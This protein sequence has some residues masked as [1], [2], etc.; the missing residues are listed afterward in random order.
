[1][2]IA[3]MSTPIVPWMGGKRRLAKRILSCFPEHKCYVEP[4]CGGAALFFS[5]EPSKV[6]VLNDINGDLINLYRVVKYR[7]EEFIRQFKW[8]LSSR[9]LFDWL[10]ET[11][12]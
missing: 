4:F 7:L 10:K 11:P 5:K 6:A 9:Q 1:M 8:A 2:S 3:L 12:P